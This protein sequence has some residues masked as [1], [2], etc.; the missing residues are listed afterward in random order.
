MTYKVVL[1]TRLQTKL[2][3]TSLT[4]PFPKFQSTFTYLDLK[5]R[6][7]LYLC[8]PFILITFGLYWVFFSKFFKVRATR[9]ITVSIIKNRH[10]TGQSFLNNI[11]NSQFLNYT[12]FNVSLHRLMNGFLV[13]LRPHKQLLLQSKSFL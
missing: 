13:L 5:T 7:C 11:L 10:K 3:R 9:T 4:I 6:K 1:L 8:F 12:G 2:S